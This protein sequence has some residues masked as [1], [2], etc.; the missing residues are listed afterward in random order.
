MKYKRKAVICDID[1]CLLDTSQIFKEIEEKGLQ[2]NEKWAY[3]ERYANDRDKAKFN[4]ILADVLNCL[5][6]QGYKI[7]FS[8]ARSEA[9]RINTKIRLQTDLG[10]MG[11][12][13]MRPL[14]NIN[15]A[16]EVKAEH[17]K[18][19][20]GFYNACIAIDDEDENLKMFS[21]NGLLAVKLESRQ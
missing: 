1:G 2:G 20:K 18:S 3:F 9:I 8:T 16:A 6:N 19:I 7:I 10:F 13:F 14:G 11:D 15:P 5:R 17:L 12:L 4:F 21:K